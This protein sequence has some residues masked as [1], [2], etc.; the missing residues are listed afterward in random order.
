M[1]R[2]QALSRLAFADGSEDKVVGPSPGGAAA[3][4]GVSRQAV[5]RA[6]DRGT[7]DAWYVATPGE[8]GRPSFISS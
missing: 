2:Y 4:L 8:G 1:S 3:E 7:L 5:H 6:I